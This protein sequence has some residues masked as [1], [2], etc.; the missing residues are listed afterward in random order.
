MRL[1]FW[2]WNVGWDIGIF[3]LT[4]PIGANQSGRFFLLFSFLCHEPF[5]HFD[6][7]LHNMEDRFYLE[8]NHIHFKTVSN[9]LWRTIT[10]TCNLGGVKS[11]CVRWKGWC[12]KQAIL[13][14]YI[15]SFSHRI[16]NVRFYIAV[17]GGDMA[18]FLLMCCAHRMLHTQGIKKF[19]F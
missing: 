16:F 10:H 6:T 19:L 2:S 13:T 15:D 12:N 11:K 7:W 18:E 3:S 1:G 17:L 5:W 8:R 14:W 4:V 9:Y